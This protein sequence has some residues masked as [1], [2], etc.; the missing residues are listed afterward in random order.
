MGKRLVSM[1]VLLCLVAVCAAPA[2]AADVASVRTPMAGESGSQRANIALAAE[3]VD[4]VRVA[5]GES[6]SFNDIVGPRTQARGYVP[7]INGRGVEV[8]GGGV[9][10]V[11][12]TLYLALLDVPGSIQFD[13]L[14]TYGSRFRAGYV[15]DGS[16]AV[17]TDYSAD[18]DFRFTNYASDML[19][20]MWISD[21]QLYCSV[22]LGGGGAAQGGWFDGWSAPAPT[23]VPREMQSVSARIPLGGDAGA[24]ENAALAAD[25]VYDTTL[26]NGGV[27]SFNQVV[28]PRT[29]DYGYVDGVN[30]RGVQVTGGGVAQVASVIWLAVRDMTD[31]AVIEKSTYGKKYNQS[32]VQN[33]ADAIVTDYA[34]GT[35]FSFRYT[36][37][38]YITLYTY[39]QDGMLVCDILRQ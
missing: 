20:R 11:A 3:A 7:A 19:I 30:G 9:S 10:Q 1:V 34:A 22:S 23:A 28:G 4:G 17:V 13:E 18:T 26:V 33:S 16:L 12:T 32:Y 6:F 31:V 24:R 2:L 35:D 15:A 27:F 29:E 38:G 39:V 36:G 21:D 25:S 14:T 5:Y 8:T 37:Q